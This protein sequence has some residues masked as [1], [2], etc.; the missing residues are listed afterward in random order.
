[1]TTIT[2]DDTYNVHLC[3]HGDA[4]AFEPLVRRYQN[5]AFAVAMGFLRDRTDAE[6]VVQDAFVAAYCKLSQLKDPAT[7]GSWL[8][9]IVVNRIPHEIPPRKHDHSCKAPNHTP[10]HRKASCVN[11]FIPHP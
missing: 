6:D 5:A 8:H 7:F 2:Q 1:M 11:P 4:N 3:L 10:G 9:R